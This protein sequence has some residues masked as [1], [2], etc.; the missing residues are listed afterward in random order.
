MGSLVGV[1]A[2]GVRALACSLAD[3]RVGV[4]H[5]EAVID[6]DVGVGNLRAEIQ[7]GTTEMFAL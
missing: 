6:L 1:A 7:Q 5:I 3:K 4:A 2:V